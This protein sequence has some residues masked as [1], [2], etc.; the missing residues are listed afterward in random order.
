MRIL[1]D[2]NVLT[3]SAQP[4]QTQYSAAVAAVGALTRRGETLCLVPQN[5]YAIEVLAPDEVAQASA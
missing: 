2:T 1:L 4:H 3:R 5:L